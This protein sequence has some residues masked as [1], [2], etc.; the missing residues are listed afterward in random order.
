MD[1]LPMVHHGSLVPVDLVAFGA[2]SFGRVVGYL[3]RLR[4]DLLLLVDGLL[5]RLLL[6]GTTRHLK[7]R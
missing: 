6:E 5:D 3:D 4:R 1:D 2:S 7:L